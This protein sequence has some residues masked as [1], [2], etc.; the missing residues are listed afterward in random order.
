[1]K[2]LEELK[3]MPYYL[4]TNKIA[5]IIFMVFV[6]LYLINQDIFLNAVYKKLAADD[7][8]ISKL[9]TGI[10]TF[11]NTAGSMSSEQN[12]LFN[13][14]NQIANLKSKLKNEEIM[15]PKTFMISDLIKNISL[16]KPLDNFVIEKI[17]FGKPVKYHGVMA[18]PVSI[19]VTGG[20]NKSVEFIKNMN[21]MKR[22]F[23][24]NYVS[25]KAS[26]K[27]FPDIES[28]IKGFIFSMNG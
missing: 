6:F 19:S 12:T 3:K 14:R 9:K 28:D 27:L 8:A 1:M 21:S 11:K 16:N 18:L 4:K 20:F 26:K 24:I 10:S 17:D 2:L 7:T 5:V 25:V 23:I 15:L 13:I 22:I